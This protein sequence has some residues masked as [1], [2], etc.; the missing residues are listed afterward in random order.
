MKIH[1]LVQ[2]YGEDRGTAVTNDELG[3]SVR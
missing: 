1:R 2:I 3:L